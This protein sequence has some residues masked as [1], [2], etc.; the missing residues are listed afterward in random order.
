VNACSEVSSEVRLRPGRRSEAASLSALALRSKGYWGYS[1]T[2]LT[3]CR[4]ELTLAAADVARLSVTV[5]EREG[6]VVGFYG[7]QVDD[8]RAEVT[9]LFVDPPAI[10]TGV[11]RT[12]WHHLVATCARCGVGTVTIDADPGAVGFYLT[13]GAERDGM[14]P[15][16]SVSGRMIPRLH[17]RL[18][19]E[20]CQLARGAE[21]E[22]L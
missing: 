22:G 2:F 7:L 20:P 1:S 11:G 21:G 15:S 9:H 13:M 12:L 6:A 18:R 17:Y 10:G 19:K 8:A 16:G 5:A 3:A 4:A 14:T